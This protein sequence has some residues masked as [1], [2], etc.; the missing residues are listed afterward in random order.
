MARRN[1]S[2]AVQLMPQ[3]SSTACYKKCSV[4]GTPPQR[5]YPA[6]LTATHCLLGTKH[7]YTVQVDQLFCNSKLLR[8]TTYEAAKP[9][10]YAW[11]EDLL[12]D[13]V[14]QGRK[15]LA[16]VNRARVH[17]SIAYIEVPGRAAEHLVTIEGWIHDI[18]QALNDKEALLVRHGRGDSHAAGI[19]VQASKQLLTVSNGTL[20]AW[21]HM[22]A[23]DR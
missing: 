17:S 19:Q 21:L 22:T 5:H 16:D 2:I 18:F 4:K 10:L 6:T 7:L 14:L 23:A 3:V 15:E 12:P 11:M 8:T 1:I 20:S 9:A 13:D